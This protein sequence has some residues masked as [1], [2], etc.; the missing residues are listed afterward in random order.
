VIVETIAPAF[1]VGVDEAAGVETATEAWN[2]ICGGTAFPFTDRRKPS[3]VAVVAAGGSNVWFCG[4]C[5][6][7]RFEVIE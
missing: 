3:T 4:C 2:R 7:G 1:E 6:G 5:P